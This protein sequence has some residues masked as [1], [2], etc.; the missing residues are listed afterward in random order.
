MFLQQKISQASMGQANPE[1]A[2]DMSLIMLI[3]FGVWM[4]HAPSGP[5]LYWLT[6]TIIMIIWFRMANLRPIVL[7]T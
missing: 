2:P 4:Y 1:G 3:M 5:V 7:E 6:N